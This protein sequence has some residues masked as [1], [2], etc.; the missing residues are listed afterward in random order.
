MEAIFN[1][2][3]IRKYK[4]VEIEDEKIEEILKS[5]MAAPSARGTEPWHFFVIRNRDI[6][7]RLSEIHPHGKMVKDAPLA[8]L[9]CYD[10]DRN[11]LSDWFQQDLSAS[12][13]NILISCTALGLGAVWLGVYPR[14]D[15]V[16]GIQEL[17]GINGEF[18][19]FALIPVGYPD[20]EKEGKYYLDHSK[21]GYID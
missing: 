2:R 14:E 18:L 1:R 8:I 12:C 3:S 21:V 4:D 20:E 10:L 19:P 16:S 5:G 13:Q 15:R 9:V 6:L 17:L 7:K 11:D